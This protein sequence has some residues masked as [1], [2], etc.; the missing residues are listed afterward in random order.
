[1]RKY[2]TDLETILN[3]WEYSG[4]A[5][6]YKDLPEELRTNIAV[7][8]F[9]DTPASGYKGDQD[10]ILTTIFE[11]LDIRQ[12]YALGFLPESWIQDEYANQVSIQE[13]DDWDMRSEERN[14]INDNR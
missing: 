14:W 11:S 2:A 9:Q 10:E 6:E 7:K 8:L 5:P 12:L 13:S 4:Y 1:M 3:E